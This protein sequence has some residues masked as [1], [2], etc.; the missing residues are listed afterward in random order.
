MKY[1]LLIIVFCTCVY[2]GIE[3]KKYFSDRLKLYE[4][5]LGFCEYAIKEISFYGTTK[6]MVLAKYSDKILSN[7][8]SGNGDKILSDDEN[9]KIKQFLE[10]IG[11]YD[12]NNEVQNIEFYKQYFSTKKQK[13][14]DDFDK[15][16]GLSIKLSILVGILLC[17]LLI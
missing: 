13:C 2:I 16:G 6:D 9:A 17:I 3:I 1:L 5:M 11:R 8:L 15:K 14:M 10:S 12:A 4:G 7:V